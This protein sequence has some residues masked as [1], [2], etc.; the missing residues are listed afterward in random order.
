MKD[1]GVGHPKTKKARGASNEELKTILGRS[2]AKKG[3]FEGEINEGELEIG[4]ISAFVKD[5]KPA[6][7]IVSDVWEEFLEAKKKLCENF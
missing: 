4:Q 1:G 5:I 2:R 3:M 7:Q 6:G